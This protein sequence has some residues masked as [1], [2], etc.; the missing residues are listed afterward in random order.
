MKTDFSNDIV[1][2]FNNSIIDVATY[3]KFRKE[4][5]EA[6]IDKLFYLRNIKD[7]NKFVQINIVENV[8]LPI[9]KKVATKCF[10]YY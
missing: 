7:E 10:F 8:E 6:S 2:G 1:V 3:K 5:L 4:E 9:E